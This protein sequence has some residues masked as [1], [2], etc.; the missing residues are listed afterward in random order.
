[1]PPP[2]P[3]PHRN[4]REICQAK[5]TGTIPTTDYDFDWENDDFSRVTLDS[6]VSSQGLK[7][8]CFLPN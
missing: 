3:T 4:T 5:E 2:P 1:M 6:F 8:R 7:S